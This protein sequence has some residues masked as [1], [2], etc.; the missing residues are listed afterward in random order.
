MRRLDYQPLDY[1]RLITSQAFLSDLDFSFTNNFVNLFCF[2]LNRHN[3]VTA[4]SLCALQI[5]S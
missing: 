3:L 2:E 5:D 1:R 4:S